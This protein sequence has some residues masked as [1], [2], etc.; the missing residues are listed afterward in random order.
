MS[1]NRQILYTKGIISTAPTFC[2]GWTYYLV[3]VFDDTPGTGNVS[4]PRFFY[5]NVND[6]ISNSM[7][8][9]LTKKNI[10]NA[11]MVSAFISCP[12]GEPVEDCPFIPYYGINNAGKQIDLINTLS[13]QKLQQLRSH[14]QS[15]I[16]LRRSKNVLESTDSEIKRKKT[17]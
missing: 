8:K 12:F 16:A 10:K 14:H 13:E 6:R 4:V 7:K 3:W 15:C 11:D 9:Y 2:V 17:S 1:E 5:P